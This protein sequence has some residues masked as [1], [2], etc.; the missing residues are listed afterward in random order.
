MAVTKFILLVPPKCKNLANFTRF[1]IVYLWV[2]IRS[3]KTKQ[4]CNPSSSCISLYVGRI[5]TS[6]LNWFYEEEELNISGLSLVLFTSL[7]SN[8]KYFGL[9]TIGTMRPM[10]LTMSLVQQ[11]GLGSKPDW[12]QSFLID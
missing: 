3:P 12:C 4:F 5:E 11:G 9:Q 7:S 8:S 1:R 6:I 2:K 10:V